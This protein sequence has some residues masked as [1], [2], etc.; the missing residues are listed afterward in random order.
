M[1]SEKVAP[2]EKVEKIERVTGSL[3]VVLDTPLEKIVESDSKGDKVIFSDEI[4]K[5]KRLTREEQDGLSRLTLAAYLVSERYHQQALDR[6]NDPD[7][8]PLVGEIRQAARATDRLYV[9]NKDPNMA[10]SWKRDDEV[11]RSVAYEGWVPASDPTLDVFRKPAGGVPVT[12]VRGETELVLMKRPKDLHEAHLREGF[13][14]SENRRGGFQK[15]VASERGMFQEG[16]PRLDSKDRKW[17]DVV[18]PGS[19]SK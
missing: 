15:Q 10:Y 16:D 17:K 13:E 19:E 9:G 2:V 12:G 11:R 14:K 6:A 18:P 8:V 1:A 4:G 3:E 5:F 7:G